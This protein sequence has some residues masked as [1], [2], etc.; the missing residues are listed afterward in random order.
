[1]E[2]RIGFIGVVME[3]LREAPAVNR[4]IG[5][6]QRIVIGRIGVPDHEND[7]AVIGLAVK[8]GDMEISALTARL[9]NVRGVSVKSAMTQK[10]L[11]EEHSNETVR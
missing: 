6:Y 11:K 1:M 4:I 10:K 7:I 3:D 8:G 9:G 2:L 5:E